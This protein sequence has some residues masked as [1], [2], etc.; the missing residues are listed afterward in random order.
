M[1]IARL[2]SVTDLIALTRTSKATR[3]AF[4]ELYELRID[5]RLKLSRYFPEPDLLLQQMRYGYVV[6]GGSRAVSMVWDY[7]TNKSSDWNF[8]ATWDTAPAF[9]QHLR[10][11]QGLK[12]ADP[13]RSELLSGFSKMEIAH[14]KGPNVKVTV[15]TP[16]ET[17]KQP[18]LKMIGKGFLTPLNCF[19][20]VDATFIG[21]PELTLNN[22][23]IFR[24]ES[25][26]AGRDQRHRAREREITSH[27]LENGFRLITEKELV[28]AQKRH[29]EMLAQRGKV[30]V[31][32]ESPSLSKNSAVPIK[33]MHKPYEDNPK[34]VTA[35]LL[36]S[37]SRIREHNYRYIDFL[38]PV[39][40]ERTWTK[41]NP[42]FKQDRTLL[43]KAP[44]QGMDSF[45]ERAGVHITIALNE[46]KDVADDRGQ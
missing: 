17:N 24:K 38:P 43:I 6:I 29:D 36:G 15:T 1:E 9:G 45:I 32:F 37:I 3:N 12:W 42:T 10:D 21:Y 7:A 5:L 27:Y 16:A 11:V 2:V 8:Y 19:S 44:G 22:T 18:I 35:A 13:V 23:M 26:S 33:I 14:M 39:W 4:F 30:N 20:T 31:R 46:K 28:G 34:Q 41:M 40:I 25:K